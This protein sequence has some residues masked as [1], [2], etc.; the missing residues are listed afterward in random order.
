MV[1]ARRRQ[2]RVLSCSGQRRVL[3]KRLSAIVAAWCVCAVWGLAQQQPTFRTGIEIFR[4]DVSVLDKNRQPVRGLTAADFTVLEDGKPQKIVALSE[5]DIPDPPPPPAAWMRDV[6]PDTTTNQVNDK[7]LF[8]IVMDDGSIP[9][10]PFAMRRAKDIA[11]DFIA[12]LG[13]ADLT[14]VVFTQDNR[15]PQDFTTDHAKLL[16]SIERTAFGNR[17]QWSY[18]ASIE[19]LWAAARFL[20]EIPERRKSL[21]YITGGVPIDFEEASTPILASRGANLIGR[22]LMGRL[23]ERTHGD[24]RPGRARQCQRLRVRRLR[25]E[26]PGAAV[27]S[28]V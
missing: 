14:A 16:A 19:T 2:D 9:F 12:R 26:A 28:R 15:R 1:R 4:L 5:I 23:V 21:I 8:V 20:I 22:E 7:R 3:M 17:T 6:T 11:R 27:R 13:P 10:D 18:Q 24:F 25:S